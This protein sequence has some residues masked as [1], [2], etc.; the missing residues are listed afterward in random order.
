MRIQWFFG[1]I[2]LLASF[3]TQA[4][5]YKYVRVGEYQASH[6]LSDYKGQSFLSFMKEVVYPAIVE[7]SSPRFNG[8]HIDGVKR[9]SG[10]E[11]RLSPNVST[12]HVKYEPHW[13]EGAERSGRS[14]AGV[15][16]NPWNDKTEYVADASYKHYLSTLESLLRDEDQVE[17]FYRVIFNILLNCDPEGI[18][19]LS[20]KGKQ[21]AA[22]FVA[23]YIAE[24]YRHLISGKGKFLGKRHNW[25]NAH[26]Q[27]TLIGAFHSGQAYGEK[28][29][30]YK[31]RFLKNVYHQQSKEICAYQRPW[32][33]MPEGHWIRPMNMTDYWQFNKECER[34]G[35]NLTRKDFKKMGKAITGFLIKE[36]NMVTP[37]SFLKTFKKKWLSNY[38]D[39]I[40]TFIVNNKA[41]R[42]FKNS[43]DL[44]DATVAWVMES[45]NLA[46]EITI[47]LSP[48][49]E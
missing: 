27:V 15:D 8:K 11:V 30:F 26:L 29:M 5:V 31:G 16:S 28:A 14:F 41:P 4:R 48:D 34:S 6:N 35:V 10:V 19:D 24:Q 12:F 47:S 42:V 13:E 49:E 7:E 22:D 38:V 40:T 3:S 23:V 1:A 2:I 46:G 25:D 33:D 44:V 32:S 43:E 39:A 20:V 36:S 45:R 37:K 18:E 9:G 17:P 21:V